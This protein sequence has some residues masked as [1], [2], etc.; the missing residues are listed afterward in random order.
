MSEPVTNAPRL[1]DS[2]LWYARHGWRVF[3]CGPR[4]KTPMTRTGFKEATR[5][6]DQIHAWWGACP[7]ANIGIATGAGLVVLDI[8]PDK[9]GDDSL[10]GL[11]AEHGRLPDTV[12]CLT[13]SGGR[14]IF[15]STDVAVPCSVATVG[16]GLDI[17]GDGGYVVAAPSVHPN[18]RRYEWELSSRPTEVSLAPIPD[19]LFDLAHRKPAPPDESST[20]FI[21]GGRNDALTRKAGSMRRAGLSVADVEASLLALNRTRCQPP[22]PDAEVKK[23]AKSSGRWPAGTPTP[24][25]DQ[26]PPWWDQVSKDERTNKVRKTFGNLCKILRGSP[27]WPLHY[28]E[29]R[30]TPVLGNKPLEAADIGRVREQLF[31]RE[32]DLDVSQEAAMQA[33]ETVAAER[34]VHPVRG[35]LEGLTPGEPAIAQLPGILGTTDPLAGVLLRKWAISA[36]AR[37]LRPGCKVDT[38]LVLVGAQQAKKTTFFRTLAGE[39]FGESKMDLRNKDAVLQLYAAWIY[40]WGEIDQVTL[41]RDASEVKQ[42]LTQ[43]TDQIRKPYG[44]GVVFGRRHSV[45]VGTTNQ[46]RYLD[47]ETGSRRFWTVQTSANIDIDRLETL[48]DRVWAEAVA[49]FKS[50]EAWWL[51]AAEDRSRAVAADVYQ[52]GDAWAE[53][54]SE[55]LRDNPQ[56]GYRLSDV[57]E[58]ALGL[59]AR[60]LTKPV[61]MRLGACLRGLGYDRTWDPS[62]DRQLR[63]RWWTKRA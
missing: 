15:F 35:Y 16:P 25:P 20:V 57:A 38:V 37:A 32:A 7:T 30:V 63:V 6:P 23:I 34:A 9:G 10:A 54:V 52:L 48:R 11:E 18:G 21:Q 36:V 58:R 50:G 55:F 40:E 5:D 44:R 3:P 27:G 14:H 62:S 56:A 17:R 28:D 51:D 42:F 61:Q 59:A 29:M 12:E 31:E 41:G 33:L 53:K 39:F 26:T 13:G 43:Q 8:D 24:P 47:D 19:W 46:A 22:L 60:D 2:A 49:A 1:L 45:I 4:K